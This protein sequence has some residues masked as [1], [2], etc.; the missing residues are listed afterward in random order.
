[1]DRH[2][3]LGAAQSWRLEDRTLHVGHVSHLVG[4]A[5]DILPVLHVDTLEAFDEEVLS[6]WVNTFG[7]INNFWSFTNLRLPSLGSLTAEVSVFPRGLGPNE[8]GAVQV[9]VRDAAGLPVEDADV[10]VSAIE[11][12]GAL[13]TTNGVTGAGGIFRTDYTAPALANGTDDTIEATATKMQYAGARAST[14]LSVHPLLPAAL[15]VAVSRGPNF[16]VGPGE[17][18]NI[19]VSVRDETGAPV[20]AARVTLR[21]DLPGGTF[22]AASGTTGAT[23]DFKTTF[24]ASSKQGMTYHIIAIV[25]ASNY[26]SVTESTSLQVRGIPGTVDVVQ[27]TRNV[28]GFEV[29]G[30]IGA[31]ALTFALV[32]LA[33]RRRVD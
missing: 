31:V 9:V 5:A 28:P 18:A 1:V 13:G 4:A 23:G 19:T 8:V 24:S 32:A 29:A 3:N 2:L 17:V 21:A 10:R 33:R 7:G 20:V 11:F 27:T 14:T 6:G 30:A 15:T 12:P 16:E 26:E 25:N 22:G